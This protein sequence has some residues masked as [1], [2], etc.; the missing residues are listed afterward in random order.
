M[1]EWTR[2]A[3][4]DYQMT[5]D[6]NPNY[7]GAADGYP[8]AKHIMI[9]MFSD[10]TALALAM[11]SG[12]I[13]MAFRQLSSTDIKDMQSDP[14]LK[15]WEGT[16]SFIQY[17]CFQEAMTPFNDA[18]ARRAIAAALDRREIV[19]TVFLG[20]GTPLYSQIPNGMTYHEDP[21]KELGD[22]NLQLTESLLRELGY[23]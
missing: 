23:G 20:Q 1:T 13:D 19:D 15:V 6:A 5:L 18:R 16:G 9:R 8:K 7:F 10:P 17:I 2:K 21:Y 14:K 4:K 12:D 3:G 11:K 22:A